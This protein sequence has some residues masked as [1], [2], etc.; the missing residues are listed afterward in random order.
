M[1]FL[2]CLQSKKRMP[3]GRIR[4]QIVVAKRRIQIEFA[5]AK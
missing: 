3:D 1:T 5:L 2:A 4:L